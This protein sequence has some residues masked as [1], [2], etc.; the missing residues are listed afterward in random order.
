MNHHHIILRPA[1][2]DDLPILQ[3][4]DQQEHVIASDPNDDWDWACELRR[5]P[6]WREQLIAELDG[7]PIGF[8]Q[9]IDPKEE[10]T[11]YWGNIKAGKRAID[12]WI[13]QKEDLGKGYGTIMMQ[14]ALERC[15]SA[16]DV[17]EVLIDPLE[18]NHDAIR[19]YKKIGFEFLEK[20][21]LGMDICDVYHLTKEKWSI[22]D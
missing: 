7:R 5:N 11:Q 13:G 1:N 20:R 19:F 9:I 3:A 12:I 8:V 10:E 21:T 2:I 6:E 18:S 22:G 14:L 16:P 17:I 15:F 4:W